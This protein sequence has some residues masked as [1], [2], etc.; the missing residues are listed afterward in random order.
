MNKPLMMDVS[1]GGNVMGYNY[2]DNSWSDPP[3]FQELSVDN[4]CSF[5]HM[6]L[7]EGNIAP[8]LGSAI[9]HGNAGYLTYFRNYASSQFA[10]PAVADF[11][12]KQDSNI[13]AAAFDAGN[14]NMTFVGNVMGSSTETDL[15][16]AGLSKI[17]KGYGDDDFCVFWFSKKG[18]IADTSLWAH[19][20]YDTVN[21]KVMWAADNAVREIPPSLYLKSKPAW[22]PGD[23]AW[24]WAGGDLTPML[25]KLPAHERAAT[26]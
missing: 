12:G 11:D 19:G 24:P 22:W 8:H 9:T 14:L 13:V 21:K 25:G 4:H 26:L 16:T 20:N 3:S 15:K 7:I 18:D 6:E 5:P 10:P 2:A 1:G 17:Y 23:M